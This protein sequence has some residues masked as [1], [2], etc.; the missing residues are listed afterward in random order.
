MES[1]KAKILIA[2]PSAGIIEPDCFESVYNMDI[3]LGFETELKLFYGYRIDDV[4]NN[5]V[6]YAKEKGFN[7]IFFVDSDMIIPKDAL[8]KLIG[9]NQ[10]IITGLY[11]KKMEIIKNQLTIFKKKPDY[12]NSLVSNN[13][14][15]MIKVAEFP[16][17]MTYM[18]IDACGFGCV[19]VKMKVFNKIA[20]PYF[21]F[22]FG[23]NRLNEDFDFCVKAKTS[24]FKIF[25]AFDVRAGHI[26]SKQF[27]LEED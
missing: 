23:E 22:K 20:Y 8:V 24:G 4:R 14:F 10:D 7:G 19:L 17:N 9:Y 15:R 13:S 26:G 6:K 2:I 3:P 5:A 11:V 27:Y 18:E 1:Q 21:N 25:V 16:K 12:E